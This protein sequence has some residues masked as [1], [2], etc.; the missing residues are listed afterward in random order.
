[1]IESCP[2]FSRVSSSLESRIAVYQNL[3]SQ[4]T[5]PSRAFWDN[6]KQAIEA[7]VIHAGRF[8]KYLRL[9]GKRVL[10]LLYS[11]ETRAEF[12]E[13]MNSLE[14]TRFYDARWNHRRWRFLLGF[15]SLG[16]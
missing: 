14:Q 5:P 4:L 6:Q 8:E 11:P 13:I 7:G 15:F 9:F 3:R 10:P 1:L 2:C 12:I 16:G